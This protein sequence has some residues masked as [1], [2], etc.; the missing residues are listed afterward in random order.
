MHPVTQ[1]VRD[2]VEAYA[3]KKGKSLDNLSPEA[4]SM[5]DERLADVDRW[6]EHKPDWVKDEHITVTR[7]SPE[8]KS[9][10]MLD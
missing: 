3:K 6:M 4:K 2:K 7:V 10:S 5:L 8:G 9:S 1:Q